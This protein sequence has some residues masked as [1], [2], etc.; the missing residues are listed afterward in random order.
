MQDEFFARLVAEEVK[1]R[2]SQGQMDYLRLPENWTRWQ[3]CLNALI[4]NL[5]DQL[6]DLYQR[7]EDANDRYKAMGEDG[8]K[9]LAE[10]SSEYEAR[11]KKITRFK[12]H[13]EARLDEVTRMIALGSS[14]I[15][16]RMKTVDFLRKAIE[17]HREMVLSNN[18]EAT[19]FDEALWAA[20]EG[21][22]KFDDIVVD[23]LV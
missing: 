16:D 1:N 12:F 5:D 7:E 19:P 3:R 18:Y 20:L 22:W 8:L 11:R 14:S 23:E 21:K 10:S 15:D 17:Q 6:D 2:V 4:D 13:V 9:L